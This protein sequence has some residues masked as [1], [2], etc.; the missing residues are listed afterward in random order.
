MC[1]F[2]DTATAR[3]TENQFL[4][5]SCLPPPSQLTNESGDSQ[6]A[7]QRACTGCGAAALPGR[8]LRTPTEQRLRRK[9]RPASAKT[10]F[11]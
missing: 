10:V 6:L 4:V 5:I 7:R 9:Q 3:I 2:H 11:A 8:S 1:R